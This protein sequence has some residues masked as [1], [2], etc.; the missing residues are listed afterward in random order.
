MVKLVKG[1]EPQAAPMS[2]FGFIPSHADFHQNEAESQMKIYAR[3][4]IVN[5]SIG[6]LIQGSHTLR[7]RTFPVI[8]VK[9]LKSFYKDYSQKEKLPV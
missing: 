7:P 6:F 5:P 9:I 2:F 1:L 4:N 8:I 3:L